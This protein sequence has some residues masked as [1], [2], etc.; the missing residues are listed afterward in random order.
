MLL[1]SKEDPSLSQ[2]PLSLN[3]HQLIVLIIRMFMAVAPAVERQED[4]FKVVLD[5]KDWRD[6]AAMFNEM[7]ADID[8][9]D[10]CC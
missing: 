6:V 4:R 8:R 1:A 3:H 2:T 10:C 5:A 9:C 7:G